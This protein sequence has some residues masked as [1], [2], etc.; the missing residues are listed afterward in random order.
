MLVDDQTSYCVFG[1]CF[2]CKPDDAVCADDN[3]MLEGVI[4]FLIPG[5]LAK[6]RSPWQRTY[7]ENQV[8]EWEENMD[9]CS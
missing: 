4:L 8:A 1:R 2:Y 6:Q 3:H 5:E 7:K 9:Y